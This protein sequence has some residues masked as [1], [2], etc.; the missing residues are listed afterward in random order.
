[1][2]AHS[3]HVISML[4][5]CGTECTT[6]VLFFPSS[7]ET[8]NSLSVIPSMDL[9]EEDYNPPV[10]PLEPDEDNEVLVKTTAKKRAKRARTSAPAAEPLET[11]LPDGNQKRK[12]PLF[13]G[14]L[15]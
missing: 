9:S 6:F 2:S 11:D 10:A 8:C 13:R 4:S 5:P 3:V 1:M 15:K 7:I 12:N 14:K